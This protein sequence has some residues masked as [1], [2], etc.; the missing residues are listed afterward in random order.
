[1]QISLNSNDL[2]S[3]VMCT[4]KR[5]DMLRDALES[6]AAQQT[7]GR[8]Q[9]EIVVVA[10][11]NDQE[12]ADV[13]QE[14]AARS[15]CEIRLVHEP[16]RG[17][18]VARNRAIAEAKGSW[19]AHFDDDQIAEPYWLKE[20]MDT[21][22][23][24][25]ARVVGG[26]L[27]LKLPEGCQRQLSY[28]C[29]R[30]LGETVDWDTERPYTRKEGPGSGNEVIHRSVFDELGTFDLAFQLRG[31]DTD[32]YRR[33]REAGIEAWYT[34]K[35]LGYHVTPPVRLTDEYFRET[36]LHNG[37]SFA[38]RDQLELGMLKSVGLL[39]ARLGHTAVMHVPRWLVARISGGQDELL[40]ARCRLWRT[41]GYA[42]SVLYHL[43]PLVFAQRKFFAKYEF[44]AEKKEM[45]PA[46]P[47]PSTVSAGGGP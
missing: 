6:L 11:S 14:I 35:G 40:T 31:Y 1:M 41:Q 21:A 36:C 26:R 7:D 46:V 12:T 43:S 5:P 32:L 25:N 2:V 44:R 4:Y 22:V 24:R 27:L 30:M 34:P 33:V 45:T 23:R 17:Q 3:I 47:A 13:V 37:W 28:Q 39:V 8:F 10:N 15:E 9:Y 19:L 38:C 18:V 42:R 20:L 16:R 29:R